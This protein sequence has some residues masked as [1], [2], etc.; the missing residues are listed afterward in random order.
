VNIHEMTKWRLLQ[1]VSLEGLVFLENVMTMTDCVMKMLSS[2]RIERFAR[3]NINPYC[4][5]CAYSIIIY[6]EKRVFSH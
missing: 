1:R 2:V 3:M 5:V 4:S 6:R